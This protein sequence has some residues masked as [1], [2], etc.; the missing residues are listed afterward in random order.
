[1]SQAD[2]VS[3]RTLPPGV[4]ESDFARA[5]DDFTAALGSAKVLTS[6]EDLRE[7]RDP[8]QFASWDEYTASAVLMPTTVEEIQAIVRIANE[9]RVPLWT[10]GTARNNGY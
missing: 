9:R 10:H 8:F 3:A 1:M 5:I 6:D 7:F 4:S 2:A